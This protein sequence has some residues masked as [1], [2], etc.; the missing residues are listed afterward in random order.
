M[1]RFILLLVC[2]F[3]LLSPLS[4]QARS[5]SSPIYSGYTQDG[6]Y[7]EVFTT[8]KPDSYVINST[9]TTIYITYDGYAYPSPTYYYT[10]T[11]NGIKYAGVLNLQSYTQA[12]GKTTAKYSGSLNPIS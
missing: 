4:A 10:K 9:I 1:K 11:S 5:L 2:F 3:S 12:D 6:I 7:F 8:D